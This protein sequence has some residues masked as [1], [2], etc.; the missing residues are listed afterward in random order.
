MLSVRQSRY[1][2][3]QLQRVMTALI[4]LVMNTFGSLPLLAER[5]DDADTTAK[6]RAKRSAAEPPACRSRFSN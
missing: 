6:F 5:D 2:A 4:L 1:G 3:Y